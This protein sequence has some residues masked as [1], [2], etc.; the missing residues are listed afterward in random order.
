MSSTRLR[1]L[2][3]T[4]PPHYDT[5]YRRQRRN[6]LERRSVEKETTENTVVDQTFTVPWPNL[7]ELQS[8]EA[9]TSC[10]N[11]EKM[12][13]RTMCDPVVWPC[14]FPGNDFTTSLENYGGSWSRTS[15]EAP[16]VNSSERPC[17]SQDTT[18]CPESY[19]GAYP[20]P[21][22]DS[23]ECEGGS[24]E[25]IDDE[26]YEDE[27]AGGGD[28]LFPVTTARVVNKDEERRL[29]TVES[30]IR[31][32]Q[33]ERDNAAVAR[34][35]QESSNDWDKDLGRATLTRACG[36]HV[37]VVVAIM[38]AILLV[39]IVAL[40]AVLPRHDGEQSLT[41]LIASASPDGGKALQI[42]SS[43]Q[44][45]ALEWLQNNT[46][47]GSYT[48]ARKLQRYSLATLYYTTFGQNWTRQDGWMSDDNECTWEFQCHG[49]D[50]CDNVTDVMFQI[51]LSSNNLEGSI[52]PELALLSDSLGTRRTGV[53]KRQN[54]LYFFYS[55]C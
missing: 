47:L 18:P 31:R 50:V 25:T 21:G 5:T 11:E 14:S 30:A 55:R 37:R 26:Q 1:W 2:V 52:P 44:H 23:E 46:G 36:R 16:G 8:K 20:V 12:L 29:S 7:N 42:V 35:V 41:D 38:M 15:E 17:A 45:R 48:N 10:K 28:I 4:V 34:V 24:W 53:V 51:C 22:I 13:D 9:A 49:Q 3:L 43:P 32:L 27:E 54:V 6:S 40:V 39:A 33:T 19:P